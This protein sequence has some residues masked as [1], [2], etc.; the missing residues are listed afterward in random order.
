ML[1]RVS[2]WLASTIR[3]P[4]ASTTPE[5]AVVPPRPQPMTSTVRL[6][7]SGFG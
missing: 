6:S 5:T 3:T 1:I 2:G 4:R 7:Y